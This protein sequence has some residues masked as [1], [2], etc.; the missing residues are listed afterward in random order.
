MNDIPG[1]RF[2]PYADQERRALYAER[3]TNTRRN[4]GWTQHQVAVVLFGTA[5]PSALSVG[6][7]QALESGQPTPFAE[8]VKEF[9]FLYKILSDC[10]T[11]Q[12]YIHLAEGN[13]PT[14]ENAVLMQRAIDEASSI[15]DTIRSSK[16]Q[17]T[18]G[19]GGQP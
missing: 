13:K 10:E 18:T 9:H 2:S 17:Y 12:Y 5:I 4:L 16:N 1:S 11:A 19:D 15:L 8:T 6:W 7:V 14:S 3:F